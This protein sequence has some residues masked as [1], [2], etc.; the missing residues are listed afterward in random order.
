MNKRWL[1]LLRSKVPP[2]PN[3][4]AADLDL[5]GAVDRPPKKK[6]LHHD[7]R[8][9][10]RPEQSGKFEPNRPAPVFQEVIW[11]EYCVLF[12][13]GSSAPFNE[14]VRYTALTGYLRKKPVVTDGRAEFAVAAT[15]AA[16]CDDRRTHGH[17]RHC[18]PR[19]CC[20]GVCRRRR[21]QCC[22]CAGR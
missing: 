1:R 15:A 18:R 20:H 9:A 21:G 19:R 5:I 10:Q 16:R 22:S 17:G 12:P 13:D 8:V 4:A 7:Q 6:H 11:N 3:M 2:Q 14:E